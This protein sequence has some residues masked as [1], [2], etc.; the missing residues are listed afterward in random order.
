MLVP[1]ESLLCVLVKPIAGER[2]IPGQIIWLDKKKEKMKFQVSDLFTFAI[3]RFS[4]VNGYTDEFKVTGYTTYKVKN[5][6]M[7][8]SVK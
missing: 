3:R 8:N 2:K 6:S 4:H 5:N 7:E 1:E